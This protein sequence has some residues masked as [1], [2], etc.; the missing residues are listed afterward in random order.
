MLADFHVHSEFSDDSTYPVIDVCRDAI[1]RNLEEICFTDHVDYGVK[2]DS[3]HPE[4]AHLIDGIPSINVDY[5]RY[6]PTVEAMRERFADDLTVRCGLE[7]GVQTHTIDRYERLLDRWGNH[8]DFA[9]L[10]IHQVGDKEF[11]D[12]SFQE[13]RTQD[14]Y[15]EA[16]YQE[17]LAVV[18]R[19]HGYSILGHLDLIKRYD[20]AGIYPF[21]KTRDITAAILERI[22]AD[23]KGIEVNTSSFRYGLP[24]LQ[25]CTEILEL[26]RDLGGTIV[27]IGSDSHEPDHLGSY[28][29]YVQRRL[30][31]LGFKAFCTFEGKAPH[32]HEL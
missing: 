32:F 2:P 15:N 30:S 31:A 22:I 17:L 25:P 6:F 14:E 9:I 29:A 26:Y 18:E 19:F 8:L 27:T 1:K 13:G 24:D 4:L 23:G 21:E 28:I 11:W 16:Y 12:G 5:D 20:P 3:D 7:L 10:S